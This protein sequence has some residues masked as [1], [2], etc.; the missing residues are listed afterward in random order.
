MLIQETKLGQEDPPHKS[1]EFDSVSLD[2]DGSG[3]RQHRGCGLMIC[4]RQGMPYSVP[5]FAATNPMELR[6]SLSTWLG[7]IKFPLLMST[8]L[9]HYDYSSSHHDVQ[10]CHDLL[11]NSLDSSV[12]TFMLITV[13][14]M[15]ISLQTLGSQRFMTGTDSDRY[16]AII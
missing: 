3:T 15:I 11:L 14:V 10:S 7:D 13:T 5:S 12:G 1:L 16:L 4:I 6:G 9:H 2:Q 8:C